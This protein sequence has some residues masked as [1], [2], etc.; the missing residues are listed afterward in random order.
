MRI[1]WAPVLMTMAITFS[2]CG[3]ATAVEEDPVK[4]FGY[5]LAARALVCSL[6]N[7]ASQYSDSDDEAEIEKSSQRRAQANACVDEAQKAVLQTYKSAYAVSGESSAAL[8]ALYAVWIQWTESL[9]SSE[10][11]EKQ[12]QLKASFEEK[13]A[14]LRARIDRK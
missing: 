13:F 12:E 11:I 3:L 5:E 9:R 8:E 10:Q 2:S 4:R 7:A 6:G 14:H 1:T